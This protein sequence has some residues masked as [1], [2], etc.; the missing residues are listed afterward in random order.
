MTSDAS[1]FTKLSY[2]DG[3]IVTF[4]NNNVGHVLS[5]S[6]IGDNGTNIENILLVKSI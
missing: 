4:E 3:R 2:K 1:K 6:T 5:K